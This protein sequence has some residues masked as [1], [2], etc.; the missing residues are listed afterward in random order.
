LHLIILIFSDIQGDRDTQANQVQEN[1]VFAPDIP[2]F[3]LIFREIGIL[4]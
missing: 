1:N 2:D 3:F 4:R